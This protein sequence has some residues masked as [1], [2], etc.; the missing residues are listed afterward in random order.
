ML[1]G[2]WEFPGGIVNKGEDPKIILRH[3]V[4]KECGIDLNILKKAGIVD[5]AFSHFSI[6]LYGYFCSEKNFLIKESTTRKWIYKKNIKDY[7]FPKLIISSLGSL[8]LKI[9][10]F[11]TFYSLIM[12]ADLVCI[13]YPISFFTLFANF[14]NS[15]KIFPLLH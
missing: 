15:K 3:K 5:H 14:T 13:L 2:L 12:L 7:T 10:M 11:K 8:K 9:G 6:R 4:F 1:G